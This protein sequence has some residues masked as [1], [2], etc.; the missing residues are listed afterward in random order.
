MLYAMVAPDEVEQQ[1]QQHGAAE[2]VADGFVCWLVIP[3]LVGFVVTPVL[4][5]RNLLQALSVAPSQGLD[6]IIVWG[7]VVALAALVYSRRFRGYTWA[8][9]LFM[10]VMAVLLI[11]LVTVMFFA[12]AFTG[13]VGG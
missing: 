10:T 1:R 13:N 9:A 7:A 5:H 2:R 12:I 4:V 11:P 3:S 6:S 8:G